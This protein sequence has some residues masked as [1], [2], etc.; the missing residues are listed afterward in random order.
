MSSILIECPVCQTDCTVE[1]SQDEQLIQPK[2]G[3]DYIVKSGEEQ[4]LQS[5]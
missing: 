3:T 4:W 5:V 2:V 1:Y